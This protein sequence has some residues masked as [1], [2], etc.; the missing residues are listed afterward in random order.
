MLPFTIDTYFAAIEQYNQ[1]IWPFP[2]AGFL[3]AMTATACAMLPFAAGVRVLGAVLVVAWLWSGIGFHL[4]HFS[5]I[6]FAA[7]AFAGLFGVEA[8]LIVWVCLVRGR[9]SFRLIPNV[10]GLAA[11]VLIGIGATS[12]PMVGLVVGHGTFASAPMFAADPTATVL[13]TLGVL[14]LAEGRAALW[15]AIIPVLWT[16]VDG[17]TFFVL[18]VPLGLVFPV[19]GLVVLVLLVLKRRSYSLRAQGTER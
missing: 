3:L 2:L 6:N 12:W 17:A 16:F 1:S 4:L 7:P 9:L 13:V 15:L 18:G 14:L 8:L 5:T 11:V 10:P 19:I